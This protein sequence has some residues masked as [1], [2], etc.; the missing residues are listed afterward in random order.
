MPQPSDYDPVTKTYSPWVML[1]FTLY[2]VLVAIGIPFLLYMFYSSA[3]R[4]TAGSTQA[5]S[6]LTNLS[7]LSTATLLYASDHDGVL[8]AVGWDKDIAKYV[9]NK[10][11]NVVF[12][13]PVQRRVDPQTS[14]YGMSSRVA[15]KD[16]KK[17]ERPNTE[18]M[19]FDSASTAFGAVLAPT[20]LPSPGRH[21]NGRSNNASYVDG[22][23]RSVSLP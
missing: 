8:P 14:G 2:S 19:L 1:K 20:N 12:S 7:D 16:A 18:I 6:C 23:V 13:C 22:H 4:S 15:G 11:G 17:L 10:D 21:N 9:K 5:D 3:S